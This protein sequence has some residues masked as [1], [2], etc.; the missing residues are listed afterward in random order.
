[1]SQHSDIKSER[2]MINPQFMV[3]DQTSMI[4][5][6]GYGQSRTIYIE[7]GNKEAREITK[8]QIQLSDIPMVGSD[9]SH[10]WL[11]SNLRITQ[12]SAEEIRVLKDKSHTKEVFQVSNDEMKAFKE[13]MDVAA[14]ETHIFAGDQDDHIEQALKTIGKTIVFAAPDRDQGCRIF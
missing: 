7:T 9:A 13:S 1:M 6:Y 5:V 8:Y 4:A 11:V 10:T 3:S 2:S 14:K 12:N